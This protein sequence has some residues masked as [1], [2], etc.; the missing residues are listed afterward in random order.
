MR[1][2]SLLVPSQWITLGLL[3]LSMKGHSSTGPSPHTLSCL[4]FRSCVLPFPLSGPGLAMIRPLTVTS[5]RFMHY[6]LWSAYPFVN[7]PP[8]I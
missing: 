3:G 4:R 7:S 1:L 6:P 5:L 8:L 2:F